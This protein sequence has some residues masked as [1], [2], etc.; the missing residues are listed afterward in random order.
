MSKNTLPVY[1]ESNQLNESLREN[2]R[3][4]G[5]MLGNTMRQERGDAFLSHVETLR[6]LA[7]K[8]HLGRESKSFDALIEYLRGLPEEELLPVTRA[9]NQ[10]LNVTNMAEQH[11]R[12]SHA[13]VEDY[14]PERQPDELPALIQRL[15]GQGVSLDR[16]HDVLSNMNID[17]VLTAH[18]T[19]VVRRTLI[20]KYDQMDQCLGA[21]E[22]VATDSADHNR[23]LERLAELMAQVWHTDEI[24]HDRPSPVD[25]AR[26]GF[27][28]IEHSL[29]QAL[30]DFYR[31]LDRQLVAIGSSP[32]P[33]DSVPL[34]F[35]SWMGG[36][37]DGNPNVTARIT[38]EV[39]YQARAAAATLYLRDLENLRVE[40]SM[41]RANEE[42]MAVTNN[43]PEPYRH[44]IRSLIDRLTVTRDVMWARLDGRDEQTSIS[45]IETPSDLFAPLQLCYQSLIDS[46]MSSIANGSLK[47]MLRRISCF[48]IT[49]TRLDIRQESE[50]HTEAIAELVQHLTGEDYL[51]W[52]EQQR[53]DFLIRE[54]ASKRP[55]IPLDWHPSADVQEVLDT[56]KVIAEAPPY[57]L[58]SYVISMATEV[59]DVLTVALLMKATGTRRLP[60]SPLFETLDDLDGA[61]PVIEKLLTIPVYRDLIGDHQQVM[62][63]YSDS[64]KDAGQLAAA[65]AQYRAQEALVNVCRQA[66]VSLTLFHGRGGTVGR[67]GGPVHAA[68]L[69]QPPGSVSGSLRVTEQGEMIRFKFGQPHIAKRNIEIYLGAVLEA[70]LLPPPVPREEWREE[71]NR[72]AGI[73][74]QTYVN[75][76]RE[77]PRFVPYFRTITPETA[78]G[79][80]A[81][82]SRPA[83]RR[84]E[85]GVESLRAIPWIFAWTQTRLM[86]P[87]WL[88][89][90]TAFAERWNDEEGRD[91]IIKMKTQW[92]FFTTYLD[93][94]EMLLAKSDPTITAYYEERLIKDPE[95]KALGKSLRERLHALTSVLLDITG[96][97]MLL[98]NSQLIRQAIALRN[99]Y[100]DPL[101]GLQAELLARWERGDGEI[102]PSLEHALMVTMAGIA[103]GLRN[104]G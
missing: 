95:L 60:I 55:L 54:L 11:Y 59:S 30:P 8:A 66:G 3:I 79:R 64:A 44:I 75:V 32:L 92:P 57:S 100:L 13:Q 84:A 69:S 91:I 22:K 99:P 52:D 28:V 34:R 78:L 47:D 16:L 72:L 50:R 18:P 62:I 23:L 103:A 5:E 36:D 74:H 25:E 39:L 77:D 24:R 9:F 71:M 14:R 46:G 19:E 58:G 102:A 56:F 31:D 87:A 6:A 81:L 21:L 38:R 61:G 15:L 12:A 17:L 97:S 33:L 90:D 51:Q 10:F 80:L 96:Q 85:G 88:G 63:G 94:L 35:A 26:W 40:L 104:T 67:G 93:L 65:W 86:L 53:Q 73:A 83:K 20:Q 45:L 70:T 37:R 68:I 7:K 41:W 2:V 98:E 27:A 89:T 43:S 4:L 101:H 82:G 48:G 49:L 1:A 42:L 76:V 29:W